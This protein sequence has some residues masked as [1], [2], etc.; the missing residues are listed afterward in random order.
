[1][2]TASAQR[3]RPRFQSGIEGSETQP[4][5]PGETACATTLGSTVNKKGWCAW[6]DFYQSHIDASFSPVLPYNA[7]QGDFVAARWGPPWVWIEQ[8]VDSI[9]VAECEVANMG[10]KTE[11]ILESSLYVSDVARSVQFYEKIFG[12]RV[13]SDFGPRGCAMQAG[14]RQY[15]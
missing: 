4:N 8:A 1:M 15:S 2:R 11:G 12:F 14:A 3:R 13:I 6:R 9:K 10:P 5:T 7:G